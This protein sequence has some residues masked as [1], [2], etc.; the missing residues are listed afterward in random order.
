M[1]RT[2]IEWVRNPDGTQGFT[3]SPITGC[4][5]GCPYCYARKLAYGRLRA[6][7]LANR[8]IAPYPVKVNGVWLHLIAEPSSDPFY[9]R[10]WPERLSEPNI[11]H[12]RRQHTKGIFVCDMGELF[13]PWVPENWTASVLDVC[14][15]NP[16]HRFY[17]LTHQPQELKKW[18]PFPPNC[19]VGVTATNRSSFIDA[20]N[21]L[22]NITASTKYISLEPYLGDVCTGDRSLIVLYMKVIDWLIIGAQTKP[23]KPPE[24]EWVTDIVEV[25]DR[26]GIAV[27][28]KDNLKP[29]MGN[30]L[31]QEW[32]NG[33]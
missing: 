8:N 7:Y 12:T 29:V 13:A 20:C 16:W 24:K 5:N 21:Y 26:A 28:I 1:N 15:R 2:R 11:D 27:F 6:R 9:P 33:K 14:W 18:S 23:Y 17:L 3:W 30:N 32:P 22:N 31:R 19:W 4:L 10:F 25:A